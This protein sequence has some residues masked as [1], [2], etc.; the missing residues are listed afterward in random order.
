MKYKYEHIEIWTIYGERCIF[1]EGNVEVGANHLKVYYP[2]LYNQVGIRTFNR[3]EI[4]KC[5]Y[6]RK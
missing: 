4:I 5:S 6:R 1:Q 2:N 3:E